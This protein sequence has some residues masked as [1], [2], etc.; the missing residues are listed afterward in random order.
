MDFLFSPP[1]A[2]VKLFD[3]SLILLIAQYKQVLGDR[4]STWDSISRV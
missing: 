1:A 4:G 2:A 3:V